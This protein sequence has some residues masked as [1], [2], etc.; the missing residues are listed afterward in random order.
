[1]DQTT[2]YGE[3]HL[4]QCSGTRAPQPFRLQRVA[5]LD[6]DGTIVDHRLRLAP[7]TVDA[8]RSARRRGHLVFLCTGRAAADI[9]PS[10]RSIGFDGEITNSGAFASAAGV[11]VLSRPMSALDAAR[12]SL[13]FDGAK[14]PYVLMSDDG[15]FA[16][17]AVRTLFAAE[18][19][20]D[21]V[22]ADIATVEPAA[23]P[24][25]EL[26]EADPATFAKA[27][28]SC[29]AWNSFES[30]KITLGNDFHVI[31][32]SFPLLGGPSGEVT[33][34]GTTKGSAIISVLDRLGID[35]SVSI[36]VGD[37]W[38][39]IEMFSVCGAGIAMGNA[40]DEVKALADDATTDVLDDGVYNAFRRYKLI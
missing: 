12:L 7:S 14:I 23:A 4:K 25:R 6:I 20:D 10:V 34:T 17:K 1:M 33:R 37:S 35:P 8:V 36:G 19:R 11:R 40:S 29:A 13:Y 21:E 39:D 5:F 22:H 24:L 9:P 26:S 18:T 27:V 32:G 28:F 15:L 2:D 30:T 31:P 3:S 38:N 16:T